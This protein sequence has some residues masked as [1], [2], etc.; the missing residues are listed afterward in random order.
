MASRRA[1]MASI[2]GLMPSFRV[3]VSHF[4][5]CALTSWLGQHDQIAVRVAQFQNHHIVGVLDASW[6]NPVEGKPGMFG[7]HIAD[8]QRQ[9]TV[10]RIGRVLVK[11]KARAGS[12]MPFRQPLHGPRVRVAVEDRGKPFGTT[13]EF[14]TT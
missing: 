3:S 4:S 11:L 12:M 9:R 7:A 5:G 13:V 8:D 14:G 10:P 2:T 6:A 1:P